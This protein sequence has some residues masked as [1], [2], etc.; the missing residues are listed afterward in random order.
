MLLDGALVAVGV[1]FIGVFEKFS[2]TL[3][4]AIKLLVVFMM[5][6]NSRIRSRSCILWEVLKI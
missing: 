6:H 1:D 4:N 3:Q 5:V 2:Y